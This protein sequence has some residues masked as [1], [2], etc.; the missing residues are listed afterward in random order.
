MCFIHLL[1]WAGFAV[2]EA[3]EAWGVVQ[4]RLRRV[5]Q[6]WPTIKRMYFFFPMRQVLVN[7]ASHT[8]LHLTASL[9]EYILC[10]D[11]LLSKVIILQLLAHE[12]DGSAIELG[13]GLLMSASSLL[14]F[15]KI[16]AAVILE[17]LQR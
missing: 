10:L 6:E 9:H 8:L 11:K 12:G 16:V 17:P 1:N 7:R 3:G 5:Y 14:Q 2:K 13:H 15:L 4:P